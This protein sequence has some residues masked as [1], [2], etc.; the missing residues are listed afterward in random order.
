LPIPV[1][2]VYATLVIEPQQPRMQPQRMR[3]H[4]AVI[5]TIPEK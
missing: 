5:M 3:E 1:F 2:G 4:V